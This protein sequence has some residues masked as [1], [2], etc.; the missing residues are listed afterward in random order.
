MLDTLARSLIGRTYYEYHDRKP[1][2]ANA[3]SYLDITGCERIPVSSSCH[4]P[5]L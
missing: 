4:G 1:N 3:I 2:H 5:A